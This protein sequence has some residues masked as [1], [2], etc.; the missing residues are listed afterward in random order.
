MNDIVF[1]NEQKEPVTTTLLIA[2]GTGVW[3]ICF[4]VLEVRK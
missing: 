2:E 4:K 3:V 1:L